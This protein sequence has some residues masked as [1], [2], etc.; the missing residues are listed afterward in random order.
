MKGEL[1]L[2]SFKVNNF[3]AVQDG[4]T[5]RFIPPDSLLFMNPPA[6]G[7]ASKDKKSDFGL[8]GRILR[9]TFPRSGI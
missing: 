8:T 6:R 1:S 4:K 7:M 9:G 5:I 2:F 3:K